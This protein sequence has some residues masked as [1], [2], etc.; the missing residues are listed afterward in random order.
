MKAINFIETKKKFNESGR[1]V[2]KFA[3]LHGFLP[4]TFGIF[5]SGNYVAAPDSPMY[6][7]MSKALRE[8][9]CLV[10]DENGKEAVTQ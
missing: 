4:G 3:R 7:E 5:L 9:G 6:Q 10:E 1:S 2:A 8:A